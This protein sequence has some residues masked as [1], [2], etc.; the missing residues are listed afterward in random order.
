MKRQQTR[1]IATIL[2]VLC[3]LP[4]SAGMAAEEEPLLVKIYDVTGLLASTT[5]S[6]YRS[7]LPTSGDAGRRSGVQQPQSHGGG[8]GGFFSV[9][10]ESLDNN[11]RVTQFGSLTVPM[12]MSHT[13]RACNC[14]S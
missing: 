11:Y 3:I 10:S 1:A 4:N 9:P 12:E 8:R 13:R 7:G 5:D 6:P 2:A 14:W